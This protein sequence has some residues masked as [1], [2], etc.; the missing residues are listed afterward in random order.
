ME[1]FISGPAA[2][3]KELELNELH[4]IA[5]RCEAD[6]IKVSFGS[7]HKF[8]QNYELLNIGSTIVTTAT[9]AVITKNK[10]ER[11]DIPHLKIA[12][13]GQF[14]TAHLLL[15]LFLPTFKNEIITAPLESINYVL[16]NKS[17][18]AL[19][20]HSTNQD[21]LKK[22]LKELISLYDLW[23]LKFHLPLPLGGLVIK[24]TLTKKTKKEILKTLEKSLSY[25]ISNSEQIFNVLKEK[26]P[27]SSTNILKKSIESWVTEETR[28]I[29]KRGY[30]AINTISKIAQ[31]E[32]LADF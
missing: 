20:I 28:N 18:C 8:S 5:N 7:L 19:V 17:D 1:N 27:S 16:N 11:E 6:L 23:K 21:Y 4:E 32:F 30:Q 12:I 9:P 14:T 31:I 24:K 3:F 26:Y 13:P 29:S 15:R 10:Y 25:A 22:G 2:H